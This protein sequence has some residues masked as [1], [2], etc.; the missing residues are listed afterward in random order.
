MVKKTLAEFKIEYM[1]IVDENINVD[2]SLMPKISNEKIKQMFQWMALTRAFDEKALKLQRAGRLG[3]Y[4]SPRGQEASITGTVAAL[5]DDDFIFP[6]Y[7]ELTAWIARNTP[8][9]GLFVAWSGDERGQRPPEHVK[10]FCIAIPLGTQ[11][12]HAV[13]YAYGIKYRKEKRIAI[14]YFGEGTS[15][16]G[17]TQIAM[18]FAGAWKL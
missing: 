1:Q 16:T 11:A 7:R 13:G 3:T 5:Q 10:N 8:L 15:S 6:T 14:T 17:S 12:L 2:E 18:N 9:D 4:A